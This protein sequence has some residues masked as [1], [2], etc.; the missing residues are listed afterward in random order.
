MLPTAWQAQV[1]AYLLDSEEIIAWLEINLDANLHFKKS[2]LIATNQ[3]LV[4]LSS[5]Q[6]IEAE[7]P[8]SAGLE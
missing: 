3:R 7:Y 8:Y 6:V 2:L 4:S 1:D 5:S